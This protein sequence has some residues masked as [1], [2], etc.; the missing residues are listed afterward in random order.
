[1]GDKWFR[2]LETKSRNSQD[3]EVQFL[4]DELKIYPEFATGLVLC[5]S[6]L[7]LWSLVYVHRASL[8]ILVDVISCN[9]YKR[10]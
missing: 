2:V 10:L 1:M 9:R 3:P 7:H 5:I 4:A 8:I 6:C